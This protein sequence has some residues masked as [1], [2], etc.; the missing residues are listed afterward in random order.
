M[1]KR[2]STASWLIPTPESRLCPGR[3]RP[4]NVLLVERS[5][6]RW[7]GPAVNDVARAPGP[8]LPLAALLR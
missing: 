4:G 7:A 8:E 3:R 5:G 6:N 2:S 1:R